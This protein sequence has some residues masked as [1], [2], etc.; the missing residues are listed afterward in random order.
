MDEF[1]SFL[2]RIRAVLLNPPP[3]ERAPASPAAVGKTKLD[4]NWM[5]T[6]LLKKRNWQWLKSSRFT[7]AK[8]EL[9]HTF[10]TY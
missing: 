6:R 2:E 8:N 10:I 1:F 7:Y 9:A 5:D 4:L 3:Q